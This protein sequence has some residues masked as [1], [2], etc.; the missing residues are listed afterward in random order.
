MAKL[1]SDIIPKVRYLIGDIL[2]EDS[3]LF[4]YENSSVFTLSEDNVS[5]VLEV[6]KNGAVL[7][8]SL[9]S[10]SLGKVTVLAALSVGDSIEVKFNFYSNYSDTEIEGYVDSALT[11]LSVNNYKDFLI[12]GTTSTIYPEPSDKELK[13]IALITSL[14]ISPDNRTYTLPNIKMSVPSDLPTIDKIRKTISIFKHN[15][16]DIFSIA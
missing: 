3:D 15:K 2:T 5:E 9:W 8:E 6:Y 16:A 11:H 13:L 1:V 7:A 12:K 10:F 4:S 14:L